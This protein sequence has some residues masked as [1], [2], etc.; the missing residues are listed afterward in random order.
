MNHLEFMGGFTIGFLLA[1]LLYERSKQHIFKMYVEVLEE[2]IARLRTMQTM[3][4][5]KNLLYVIQEKLNEG[6]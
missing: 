4:D 3:S 5:V 2:L 6:E 1:T